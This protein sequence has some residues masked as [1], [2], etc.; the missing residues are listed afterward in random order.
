MSKI[1]ILWD[2]MADL[3]TVNSATKS[4]ENTAYPVSNLYT[5]SRRQKVWRSNGYWEI[6]SGSNT[7]IFQETIGVNLTA[8][9]TAGS[10]TSTTI[11]TQIKSAL[12]ATGDST[13]TVTFDGTTGKATIASNGSGGT[14]VFRLIWTNGS[15]AGMAAVLGFDTASDDN[16]ALTYTAD[17]LRIHTSEWV[18]WDMGLSVNPQ[19]FAIIGPRNQGIRLSPESVVKIQGN[20]TDVWTSPSYSSTLAWD[21]NTMLT[22]SETGLH[23]EAL[24]YW[25]LYV[26]D[27]ANANGYIELSFAFLGDA[28]IPTRGGVQFPL[29]V[30]PIDQSLVITSESGFTFAD[31]RE[32]TQKLSFEVFGLTVAEKEDLESAFK[33]VGISKSFFVSMDPD[34]VFGSTENYSALF[35][36][37]T[38]EPKFQLVSPGVYKAEVSLREEL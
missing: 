8:T 34:A 26:E 28:F 20:E 14:G 25:R 35:V 23:T 11:L 16:G 7:I 13:Y 3:T 29:S 15:S 17:E 27:K 37:F 38:N 31:S 19:G 33:R 4:S 22:I 32:K 5:S 21:E 6:V 2:N 12:E 24:R 10:Y 36:K 18:K 9:L 1:R 30:E